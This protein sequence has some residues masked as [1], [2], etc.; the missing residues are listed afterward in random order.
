MMEHHVKVHEL[1]I[2]YFLKR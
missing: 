1:M 2:A